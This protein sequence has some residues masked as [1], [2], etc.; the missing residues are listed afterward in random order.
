M[1][2]QIA[3]A[4]RFGLAASLGLALFANAADAAKM[5]SRQCRDE[6]RA[7]RTTFKQQGKSRRSFMRACRRGTLPPAPPATT[8]H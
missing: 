7:N 4:I 1:K 5:S 2:K 6:W 8:T 3:R